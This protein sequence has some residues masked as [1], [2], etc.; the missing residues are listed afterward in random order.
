MQAGGIIILGAS[1]TLQ[2]LILVFNNVI[3]INQLNEGYVSEFEKRG[4]FAHFPNFGF[5]MLISLEP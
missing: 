4:N 5:K 2:P 3:W 1:C